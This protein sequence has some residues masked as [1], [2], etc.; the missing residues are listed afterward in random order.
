MSSL[1]LDILRS[2]VSQG[3]L[4]GGGCP[5]KGQ[6]F[7]GRHSCSCACPQSVVTYCTLR[8]SA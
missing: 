3:V 2:P 5:T 8:V 4:Q 1:G 7:R 6:G